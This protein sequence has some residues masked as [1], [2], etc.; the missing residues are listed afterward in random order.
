MPK[1]RYAE[2]VILVEDAKQSQ[3]MRAWLIAH[4]N[5][6]HRKI[7]V[8]ISPK[9]RGAGEQSVRERFPAEAVMHRQKASHR[10]FTGVIIKKYIFE[11]NKGNI[12]ILKVVR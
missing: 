6:S 9:G 11:Y 8:E 12:Y 1:G 7:R 10:A 3:F 4:L 2:I 5:V